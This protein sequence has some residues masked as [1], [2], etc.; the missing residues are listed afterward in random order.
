MS[1]PDLHELIAQAYDRLG[2]RDSARVHWQW[3]ATALEH[4]DSIAQP[5][6]A[7]ALARLSSN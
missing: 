4:A 2:Q 3:L 1:F 6:R 7:A 5:R